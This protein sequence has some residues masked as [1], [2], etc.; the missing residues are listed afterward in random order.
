MDIDTALKYMTIE[1]AIELEQRRFFCN[2][3]ETI[4]TI[5][6]YCMEKQIP[7]Q[8]VIKMNDSDVEIGRVVFKAG[9]KVHYCP[10]CSNPVS[11]SQHFC[12]KCGQALIW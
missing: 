3:D 2:A 8:T 1:Q 5:A 4:N 7:K 12:G 10:E 9:A 6:V 11:G